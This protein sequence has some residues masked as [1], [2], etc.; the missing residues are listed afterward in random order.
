MVTIIKIDKKEGSGWVFEINEA[1]KSVHG[2]EIFDCILVKDSDCGNFE[3]LFLFMDNYEM[4]TFIN[5]LLERDIA[6]YSKVD[7]TKDLINI[8]NTNKV[9]EFKSTF[10]Q[11][12]ELDNIINTFTFNHIDI[13]MV[14]D[15]ISDLGKSGLTENDFAIL[16]A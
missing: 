4:N 8:V 5:L 1:F 14:L 3:K 16:S 2:I 11:M 15:K 9:S 12:D 7:F 6:V 13:D 10:N